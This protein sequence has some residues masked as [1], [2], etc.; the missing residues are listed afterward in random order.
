ML[1]RRCS[2]FPLQKD[3]WPVAH[4]LLK[5]LNLGSFSNYL[6]I[7]YRNF[8]CNVSTFHFPCHLC[9]R[10]QTQ[11]IYPATPQRATEYLLNPVNQFTNR[12]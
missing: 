4:I 12:I 2:R 10:A 3:I 6:F 8:A 9:T 1:E 7:T 11:N 5:K